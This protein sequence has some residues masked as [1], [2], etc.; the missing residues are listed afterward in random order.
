MSVSRVL[1]P[2]DFSDTD[3]DSLAIAGALARGWGADLIALHVIPDVAE[4][5]YGEKST[6]GKDQAAWALWKLSKDKAEGRLREI[7]AGTLPGFTQFR[8]LVTFGDPA[9]RIVEVVREERI[10]LVVISARRDRTLLQEMLLGSVA[11]KV[12]RTVSSNVMLV[13]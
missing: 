4:E 5:V 10:G 1:W 2:T 11:Y 3:H 9:T 6:E 7:V 12:V 13:K 8:P